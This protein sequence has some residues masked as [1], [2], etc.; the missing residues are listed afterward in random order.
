[1]WR[2]VTGLNFPPVLIK[3][4]RGRMDRLVERREPTLDDVRWDAKANVAAKAVR[5]QYLPVEEGCQ[6]AS[7]L[8]LLMAG[9]LRSGSLGEIP[10]QYGLAQERKGS[11]RQPLA[12]YLLPGPYLDAAEQRFDLEEI[13]H[14]TQLIKGGLK[15]EIREPE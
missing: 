13:T 4:G 15:E 10:D 2:V 8:P 6:N 12:P 14:E 1:M 7:R 3:C 11:T 5:Y 9:E